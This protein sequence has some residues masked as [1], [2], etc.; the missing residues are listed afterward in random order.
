VENKFGI[1]DN[2]EVYKYCSKC[3]MKNDSSSKFCFECGNDKFYD[4][5]EEYQEIKNNKYCVFC[6]T[7][8]NAKMK[9]CP[10]CGK[11]E[12]VNSKEKVDEIEL[13]NI[14][15]SWESK[16]KLKQDELDNLLESIN[17]LKKEKTKLENEYLKIGK[18]YNA[19]YMTFTK[20]IKDLNN[21]VEKN[22]DSYS[23]ELHQLQEKKNDLTIAVY[24]LER[25]LNNN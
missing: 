1:L 4:T 7:K 2:K 19:K 15:N 5:L 3:G 11:N 13:A 25:E 24:N 12:F 6:K 22:E 23:K 21:K 14:S 17:K 20:D 18:E 10:N 16:I 8:V 9:F